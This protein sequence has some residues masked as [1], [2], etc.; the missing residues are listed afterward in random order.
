M[1]RTPL[2]HH[3][4]QLGGRMVEFAGWAMPV[5]YIGTIKEHLAVREKAGIFDVSHMGEFDFLGPD[6]LALLQH[7]T[8]NN[9]AALADGQAQYSM[10]L[11][12][13]GGIIDDII[14]YRF[15]ADH[16]LMV[17]NA[18]NI[19]TDWHWVLA[20]RE[21]DIKITNQSSDTALIAL[22]GVLAESI[23][24]P[25]TEAKLGTLKRFT[26]VKGTIA[27]ASTLIARTGYTGAPGFEIFVPSAQA[28]T[29]WQT[30]L[31]AGTPRGLL[32]C[33]LAARDTLR[34]EMGYPLHG[35][36]ISPKVSPLEARLQWVVKLDK[37]PFIGRDA[38]VQLQ[39]DGCQRQL[40]GFRMIDR[41]IPR[42]GYSIVLDHRPVGYVTSGT[43]SP[44]L[45]VG[46]GM[47]FVP[48]THTAPGTKFAIDIRGTERVAEVVTLPFYQPR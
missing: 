5:Q 47:G 43:I 15:S 36:D 25:L 27:S 9:V 45:Q 10:L 46:I 44:C 11:N 34:L 14:I 37:G 1:K 30:L 39:Q 17:V 8:V 22:Q 7:L 3:H 33:G 23:L 41:G 26:F 18:G 28:G 29:V 35:H 12:E 20:H 42:E 19:D 31:D 16:Y 21:G 24:Q 6:A 48:T 40:V 2:Y 4:E 13:R 32:P 38:L